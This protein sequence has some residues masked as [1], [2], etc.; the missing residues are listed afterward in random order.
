LRPRY[1]IGLG[2]VLALVPLT[3][4]NGLLVFWGV[5]PLLPFVFWKQRGKAALACMTALLI[6]GGVKLAL[7]PLLDISARTRFFPVRAYSV[8]V[9]ALVEA[10]VPLKNGE[11]E[12]IDSVK[13]LDDRWERARPREFSHVPSHFARRHFREYRALDRSLLERYPLYALRRVLEVGSYLV[14]PLPSGYA[15]IGTGHLGID[16]HPAYDNKEL[17]LKRDPLLPS[18]TVPLEELMAWSRSRPY[19]WLLWR[20]TIHLY[21]VLL[22]FL[23]L[24]FRIRDIRYAVVY[25]PVVLN[26]VAI[27]V[28][29]TAQHARY[30]FPLTV[31]TGTLLALSLLPLVTRPKRDG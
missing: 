6:F 5:L 15:N 7:F 13:S 25:A 20:P 26:T 30:Q 19:R 9:G 28:G 10:D 8:R 1:W 17:G 23:L 11:L 21:A 27:A 22:A 14:K 4:H 2:V 18:L 31:A 29:A 12:F 16:S 24:G 3:R